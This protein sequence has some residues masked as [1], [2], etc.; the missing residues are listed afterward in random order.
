MSE[1]NS[2]DSYFTSNGSF[3]AALPLDPSDPEVFLID[4]VLVGVLTESHG[5][6]DFPPASGSEQGDF[7]L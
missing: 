2:T 6:A 1:P 5:F 7:V 4:P 3:A